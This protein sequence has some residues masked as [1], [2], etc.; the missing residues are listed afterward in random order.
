MSKDM[1]IQINL[2]SIGWEKSESGLI[3]LK[4]T[5]IASNK[6][7]NEQS[8][9]AGIP[10]N[11][12]QD[13]WNQFLNLANG[14]FAMICKEK[15]KIIAAVDRIRSIPLFYS[16][17]K[18]KIFI[19]DNAE[20]IRC[21]ICDLEMDRGAL[22]EMQL[23]GYVTG[24]DTLYPNIKQL[25]AGEMLIIEK[26]N[27]STMNLSKHRYYRFLH[28]EPKKYNESSLLNELDKVAVDL[29]QRLIDYADGRQI[30]IPLSGGYDSRL[31]AILLKRLCYNN[32][33]A[34]TY[35]TIGNQESN[36]SKIVA[37]TLGIKWHFVEYNK[38][39]WKGVWNQ[40]ER[41][42]FQ[43]WASGYCTTPHMQ[44]WI[45]VKILKDEG[46]IDSDCVIVPGHTGDFVAGGHIPNVVFTQAKFAMQ[47]IAE[48]IFKQH[49]SL[50][51][52]KLF[53]ISKSDWLKR[54]LLTVERTTVNS[55]WELAD[56][57]EKWNWQERQAKFICNSVRAY[58]YFGYD[59]WLPLWDR[60]FMSFWQKLPLDLRKGKMWYNDYVSSLFIEYSE[61]SNNTKIKNASTRSEIQLFVQN[62]I[63]EWFKSRIN[64]FSVIRSIYYRL[65]NFQSFYR[66]RSLGYF[67][68]YPLHQYFHLIWKGFNPV[69]LNT[70]VFLSEL[71]N[72]ESI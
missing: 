49:Y 2:S 55:P 19:S 71:N 4:G 37:D 65:S 62:M 41:W 13:D 45:A 54:I 15:Q 31:I 59:W 46:A 64:T 29:I 48:N 34:F 7:K 16:Q 9:F 70:K 36:D 67:G 61:N 6:S 60:A 38:E 42:K 35:G 23:T 39:Q 72:K 30:V 40:N 27:T 44:D 12:S 22:E 52:I 66:V 21:K 28:E 18:K 14:F 26:T 56:G 63:P 47:D 32:V 57:I 50:A 51:P 43:K 33:L 10:E 8:A 58:E 3:H 69:G 5:I 17:N 20:W 68:R 11:K 1:D 53:S 24:E 25:Q